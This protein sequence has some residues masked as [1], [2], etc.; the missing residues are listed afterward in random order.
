ML[1]VA[2]SG[3]IDSLYALYQYAMAAHSESVAEPV[4]ALHGQFISG[5]NKNNP[6]VGLEASCKILGVPLV[7]ADLH[8]EFAQ[9]VVRPFTESYVRGHTPNPCA[10]CNARIK[11]GLLLDVAR[12][13][14]ADRLVTG[15]YARLTEH[16]RYGLALGAAEDGL[17]DQS[18]FLA[19]TAHERLACAVFPLARRHKAELRAELD[20]AGLTIPVPEESQEICFV[21]NADYRAFLKT[22]GV[23]LPSGGPVVLAGTDEILGQHKGLWRYTEG[24]RRGLGIAWRAPLYVVGKQMHSNTLLVG[25]QEALL[26]QGCTA[27]NINL[28]VPTE[29]WPEKLLVRTRY[30][31]NAAPGTVDV[32]REKLHIRFHDAQS[33]PAP[34]QLAA[35]YD[36]NGFVLAGGIIEDCDE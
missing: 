36:E 13:N 22:Q 18:Y 7:V 12:K 25:P 23:E 15:H 19:L 27:G 8:E 4:L 16:P 30:R 10:L 21:P 35:V 34:G 26:V 24:Q 33:R 1:A 20:A 14:G 6:V 11:F 28:L 2:V 5:Q 32:D 17:K 29:L 3:G 31:Q 9:A